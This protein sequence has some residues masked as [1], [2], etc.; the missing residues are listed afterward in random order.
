[1]MNGS[2]RDTVGA[3][4]QVPMASKEAFSHPRAAHRKGLYVLAKVRDVQR[5][6]FQYDSNN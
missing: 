5:D 6:F 4:A 1:M 3:G 2:Q